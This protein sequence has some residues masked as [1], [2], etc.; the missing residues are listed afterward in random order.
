MAETDEDSFNI[1]EV[2]GDSF[3]TQYKK[4]VKQ[5]KDDNIFSF[6]IC[7]TFC[8]NK[9]GINRRGVSNIEQHFT[10]ILPL[11]TRIGTKRKHP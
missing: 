2:D 4:N 9:G 6:N 11:G 3:N 1:A 8:K 10:D 7:P 5:K